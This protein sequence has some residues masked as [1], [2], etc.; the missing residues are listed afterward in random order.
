MQPSDTFWDLAQKYGVKVSQLA[1]WNG[2]APRDPLF[3]GQKLIIWTD[4]PA[5][6]SAINPASFKHPHL[7][8]LQRRIAYTVRRGDSLASIS[9]RF[10]VRIKDMLR[11]NK[12]INSDNYLQ[13]GQ[14]LTLYVDVVRQSGSSSI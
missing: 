8:D 11:W 12:K 5:Q 14:R 3:P 2:M 9:Q 4:K 10:R 13:P 7:N 6:T 1:K